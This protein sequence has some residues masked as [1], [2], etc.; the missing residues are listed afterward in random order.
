MATD[1]AF[2]GASHVAARRGLG[3]VVLVV[4]TARD[5]AYA[6]G[7]ARRA[8]DGLEPPEARRR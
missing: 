6:A 8:V 2:D 3:H 4:V 5:C 1:A 7:S